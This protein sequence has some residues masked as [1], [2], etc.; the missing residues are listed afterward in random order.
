MLQH[1]PDGISKCNQK[2]GLCPRTEKYR[3]SLSLQAGRCSHPP[4]CIH[5]QSFLDRA[6]QY[7]TVTSRLTTSSDQVTDFQKTSHCN[8]ANTSMF[9]VSNAQW[10]AFEPNNRRSG[11]TSSFDSD[12]KT[13]KTQL[14]RPILYRPMEKLQITTVEVLNLCC[15]DV[16][17]VSSTRNSLQPTEWGINRSPG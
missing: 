6:Q 11:A 15:L 13:K 12:L 4:C 10:R 16:S 7:N 8:T 2:F 9:L 1:K 5:H 3:F 14:Y 17:S